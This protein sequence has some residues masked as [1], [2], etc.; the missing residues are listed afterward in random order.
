MGSG[1]LKIL[2]YPHFF[3]QRIL[4]LGGHV[5]Q[6]LL[7]RGHIVSWYRSSQD[8]NRL[9]IVVVN[10]VNSFLFLPPWAISRVVAHLS[11]FEACPPWCGISIGGSIGL[12]ASWFP[13]CGDTSLV[14]LVGLV[15][16][17]SI[18]LSQHSIPIEIHWYGG[19]VHL[20]RS[21]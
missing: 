12:W 14:S 3:C 8:V 10:K 19:V 6:L 4:F 13:K 2:I 21:I 20:L 16:S 11:T 5:R 15:A 9:S 7:H 18:P 1:V 17:P